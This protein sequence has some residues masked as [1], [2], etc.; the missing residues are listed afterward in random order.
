MDC[1]HLPISK[2]LIIY[3][4]LR[5][6]LR[7]AAVFK[8]SMLSFARML[9]TDNLAAPNPTNAGKTWSKFHSTR[10]KMLLE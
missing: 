10:N 7:K 6:F 4:S 2:I 8:I 1:E 9:P 3:S 5:P